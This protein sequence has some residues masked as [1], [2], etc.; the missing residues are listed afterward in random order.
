MPEA[1]ER[2]RKLTLAQLPISVS[3]KSTTCSFPRNTR[4]ALVQSRTTHRRRGE[5]ARTHRSRGTKNIPR[6]YNRSWCLSRL[7]ASPWETVDEPLGESLRVSWSGILKEPISIRKTIS[8]KALS[9]AS[10]RIRRYRTDPSPEM[11]DFPKDR[12]STHLQS[13]PSLSQ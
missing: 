12:Q 13:S 6:K 3:R 11:P 10:L 5:G 1:I 4:C 8:T 2:N 7:S 9:D